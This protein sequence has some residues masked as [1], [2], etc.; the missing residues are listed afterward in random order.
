MREFGI[1]VLIRDM[2]VK[3]RV[4][5][6]VC[7]FASHKE[8]A[9]EAERLNG[10][11]LRDKATVSVLSGP[12]RANQPPTVLASPLCTYLEP[13][14]FRASRPEHADH[15]SSG[16]Y[17]GA[18][19]HRQVIQSHF[20]KGLLNEIRQK[21]RLWRE[22]RGSLSIMISEKFSC[23]FNR[24]LRVYATNIIYNGQILSHILTSI[25]CNAIRYV[26]QMVWDVLLM[27]AICRIARWL[28]CLDV[29]SID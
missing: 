23:N 1:Y 12:N 21:P 11:L 18:R 26:L 7:V 5:S 24:L 17:L 3:S 10:A 13:F 25:R 6:C 16:T 19:C 4:H 27:R 22:N 9:K 29:T 20:W 8:S 15:P 2:C 14:P 28:V